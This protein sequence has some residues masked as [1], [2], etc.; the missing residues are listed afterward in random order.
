VVFKVVVL[1]G[2]QTQQAQHQLFLILARQQQTQVLFLW[3]MLVEK[4]I[5]QQLEQ[6]FQVAVVVAT[7]L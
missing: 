5:H 1:L 7:Q 2:Q 3:V 4:H 6:A